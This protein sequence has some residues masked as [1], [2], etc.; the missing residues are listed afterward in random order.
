MLFIL[1]RS[2]THK[3]EKFTWT[4]NR[5][6][7]WALTIIR[8]WVVAKLPSRVEGELCCDNFF[9]QQPLSEE[10]D[11]GQEVAIHHLL[12]WQISY[13]EYCL[14]RSLVKLCCTLQLCK[15]LC[16]NGLVL[17]VL[18]PLHQLVAVALRP[19]ASLPAILATWCSGVQSSLSPIQEAESLVVTL[20]V[21]WYPPDQG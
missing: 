8:W 2:I 3:F 20:C 16:M 12:P 5:P 17:W 4:Q 7:F 1:Y 6:R 10:R 14:V 9:I 21:V 11:R 19:I 15:V 13:Q 18:C